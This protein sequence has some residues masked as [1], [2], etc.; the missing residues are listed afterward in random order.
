MLDANSPAPQFDLIRVVTLHAAVVAFGS[1]TYL[2]GCGGVTGSKQL[3]LGIHVFIVIGLTTLK[4]CR[5][6]GLIVLSRLFCLEGFCAN[7]AR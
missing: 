5:Y 6:L 3:S 1:L 7:K 2:T 4:Y